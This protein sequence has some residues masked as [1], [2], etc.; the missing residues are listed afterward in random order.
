MVPE[1]LRDFRRGRRRVW[2]VE[3]ESSWMEE[4]EE[5]VDECMCASLLECESSMWRE[6]GSDAMIG[7][8]C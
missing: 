5:D 7:G 4:E 8:L 1:D 2:D 6:G 3:M